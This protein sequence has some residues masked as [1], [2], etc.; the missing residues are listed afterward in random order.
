MDPPTNADLRDATT[1]I[2]TFLHPARQKQLMAR[3]PTPAAKTL[4]NAAAYFRP[5]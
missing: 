5:L 1:D 2:R 3:R 4:K